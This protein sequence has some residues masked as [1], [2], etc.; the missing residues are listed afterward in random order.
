MGRATTIAQEAGV[1]V[2]LGSDLIGPDQTFRGLELVLR[3]GIDGPMSALISATRINAEILGLADQIGT[4][5]VGKVA[6]LVAF[7]GDPLEEPK[8][9]NDRDRVALVVQ[10]GKVVKNLRA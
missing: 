10:S 2:G 6:D 5:E 9:F 7:D 4:V 3:S 1:R 8:L